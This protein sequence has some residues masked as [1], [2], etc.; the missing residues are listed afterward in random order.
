MTTQPF[1][2]QGDSYGVPLDV[3]S[4]RFGSASVIR[5]SVEAESPPLGPGPVEPLP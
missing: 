2:T 4:W 1:H 5:L 3:P